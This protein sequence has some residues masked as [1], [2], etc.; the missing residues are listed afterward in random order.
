MLTLAIPWL[1]YTS[2]TSTGRAAHHV[3]GGAPHTH[4]GES[5]TITAMTQALIVP[6]IQTLL[7]WAIQVW[8]MQPE[9]SKACS[10]YFGGQRS[11]CLSWQCSQFSC[12][13]R[14][15]WQ[16]SQFTHGQCGLGN[17]ATR[18]SGNAAHTQQDPVM[19]YGNAA[20]PL[21]GTTVPTLFAYHGM[22]NVMH[23]ASDSSVPTQYDNVG[24]GS[25]ASRDRQ[26]M[27][28]PHFSLPTPYGHWV[29]QPTSAPYGP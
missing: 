23:A 2:C 25:T 13:L 28:H 4:S 5:V 3:D 24:S 20:Y 19:Y 12:G 18:I 8:A 26:I 6:V 1:V 22:G 21:M 10:Q 29:F 11:P 16:C 27:P 14:P 9:I 7:I 15:P 17:A